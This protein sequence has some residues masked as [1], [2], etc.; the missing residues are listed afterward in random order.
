M[1]IL[2]IPTVVIGAAIGQ[3]FF[4]KISEAYSNEEKITEMIFKTWKILFLIG[5]VPTLILF[6]Y[7]ENLFSIIFGPKWAEAGKISEYLCILTFIMFISS[8]T[9]SAMVVLKKQK[10]L[11]WVNIAAFIYRPLA[12]YLG[13]VYKNFMTGIILF[14][15]FEIIQISIYNYLL[16]HSARNSD[17]KIVQLSK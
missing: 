8:P 1:R 6:F 9:S 10:I 12:F 3:V 16:Y 4:Q 17:L 11:L 2:S 15:I 7:G 14:V 5:I 13:Y